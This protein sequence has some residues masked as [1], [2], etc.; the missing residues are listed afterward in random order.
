MSLIWQLHL[1]QWEKKNQKKIE[2]ICQIF[3]KIIQTLPQ[4]T[5]TN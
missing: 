2:N 3:L 4:M 5:K 1:Q